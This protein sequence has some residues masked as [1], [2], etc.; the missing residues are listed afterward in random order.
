MNAALKVMEKNGARFND[1]AMPDGPYEQAA[2]L[3]ILMEAVSSFQDLI[4]SGRCVELD[5]P[6]GKIN[7]YAGNEFSVT[8]Y[9][10]VQRVRTFLQKQVDRLFDHFDV[11]AT[12]GEWRRR[13][14]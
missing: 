1:V 14:Y 10:Q 7:G 12:A 3:T 6:L 8:D 4:A 13:R 2:E 9:L 5:D 11:L